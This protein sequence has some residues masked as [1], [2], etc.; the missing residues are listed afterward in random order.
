MMLSR[1]THLLL[2][3]EKHMIGVLA[4]APK[5]P[6]WENT[7]NR[8]C[9]ILGRLAERVKPKKD[10][11]EGRRGIGKYVS[12]GISLGNGQQVSTYPLSVCF[13]STFSLLML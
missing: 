5:D 8:A 4:G 2:D 7:C 13:I 9:S 12:Y 1:T 3:K 6:D 11:V 10:E